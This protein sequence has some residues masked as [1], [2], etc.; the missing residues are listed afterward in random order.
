M[1]KE[2]ESKP[3]LLYAKEDYYSRCNWFHGPVS[4]VERLSGGEWGLGKSVYLH[5]GD[6]GGFNFDTSPSMVLQGRCELL[7]LRAQGFTSTALGWGD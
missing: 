5:R 7:P 3:G 1:L 2:E 6:G 4:S